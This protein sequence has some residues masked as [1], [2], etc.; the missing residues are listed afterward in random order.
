MDMRTR[1]RR[2]LRP[3]RQLQFTRQG[4]AFTG[5]TFLVGMGAINTGNNLLYL[6][7]GLMLG[8]IIISGGYIPNAPH[9]AEQ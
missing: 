1:L 7:L 3:P 5:M 4:V 9:H 6:M 8:L 2:F